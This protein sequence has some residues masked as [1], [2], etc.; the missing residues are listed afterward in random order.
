MHDQARRG[1]MAPILREKL[2][3]LRKVERSNGKPRSAARPTTRYVQMYTEISRW[4]GLPGGRGN[5]ICSPGMGESESKVERPAGYLARLGAHVDRWMGCA[6][7]SQAP[8][9]RTCVDAR[10]MN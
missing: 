7:S 8:K 2:W 4:S 6:S 5:G 9:Q 1:V 3:S 10:C